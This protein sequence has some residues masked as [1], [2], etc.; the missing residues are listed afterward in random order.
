MAKTFTPDFLLQ[1][2]YGELT[3]SERLE[4]EA[5]CNQDPYLRDELVMINESKELLNE[6]EVRP[7][8]RTLN[9]ILSFS[10][11]YH[12]SNLSNGAQAEMVLN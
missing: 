7:S 5:L 2:S 9:N 3:E 1:Y 11:A 4:V 12:V 8:D 10:K 6:V